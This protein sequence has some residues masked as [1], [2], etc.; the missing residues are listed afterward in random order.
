[1]RLLI[2]TQVVDEH[3]PRLSF[4]TGWLR[5]FSAHFERI[6]VVCLK[7]GA[8]DPPTNVAVQSLGKE[9]MPAS[10]V[11]IVSRLRYAGRFMRAVW[12]LRDE[13]DVVLVHMNQE[14]VLLAGILWLL[15]GKRV[16]LWRNHYAGSYL[17]LVASL[18]CT[19]VFC[20][21]RYS[22]TRRFKNTVIMPVGVEV[23]AFARAQGSRVPRSILS[24]GRVSPS[25]HVDVLIEAVR[26]LHNQTI[27]FS[28]SIYGDSLPEEG[29]FLESLRQ[30]VAAAHLDGDIVFEGGVPHDAAPQVFARHDVFVNLSRSGMLDKTIF[31]ACAAGCVV[32]AVSEDFKAVVDERLHIASLNPSHVAERIRAVL[33]MSSDE[34][35]RIREGLRR[36]SQEHSIGNLARALVSEMSV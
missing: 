36:L 34:K 21:S 11:R 8:F 19:K 16:Y 30:A 15:M 10:V 13:Y 18:F 20:T 27:P 22:Y 9:I 17:T 35:D 4:V 28:L 14:Y 7:R 33:A 29:E 23:E 32:L 31:E 5:E 12:R 26:T 25:K 3:D 6:Q 24:F 2:C 1:M